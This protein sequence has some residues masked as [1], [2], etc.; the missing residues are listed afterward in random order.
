MSVQSPSETSARRRFLIATGGA[1]LLSACGGGEEGEDFTTWDTKLLNLLAS[2]DSISFAVA[3]TTY[4]SGVG[5]GTIATR[6]VREDGYYFPDLE[7]AVTGASGRTYKFEDVNIGPAFW[8]V[9]GREHASGDIVGAGLSL[10][11]GVPGLYQSLTG[12]ETPTSTV[13]STTALLPASDVYVRYT[14][15]TALTRLGTLDHLTNKN[16]SI[17]APAANEFQLVLRN[18]S[19]GATEYDSGVRSKPADCI[20]IFGRAGVGASSWT[21][22]VIDSKFAIAKW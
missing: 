20:F 10:I 21:L 18:A 13:I 16:V 9:A 11:G 8:L 4:L 6:T 14:A 22:Y 5:F 17:Q 2:E 7:V 12:T 19:T 15:G 3:G 1:A